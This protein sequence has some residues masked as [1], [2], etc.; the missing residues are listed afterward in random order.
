MLV[1]EWIW[2]G[3]W[4][5]PA[6]RLEWYPPFR[7]MGVRVL[8]L[9][10]DWRVLRLRLPLR[11]RNR[12]PGG[13]R[14]G[15][16]IAMLADPIPA[17]SCNRVFPGQQVWTRAMRLDF[18]HESRTDLE[19]RF[20]MADDAVQ[21]IRSELR[22]RGRATPEFEFGFYDRKDRLCVHVYNTVAIR[23]GDYRPGQHHTP[24]SGITRNIDERDQRRP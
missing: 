3:R 7:A 15:G 22:R 5:T 20:A 10:P 16:A 18:R 21:S 17:L 11:W 4:V 24:G 6:R 23:P 19:L 2:K 8:E 12:N 14:F 9:A 13:G 1:P